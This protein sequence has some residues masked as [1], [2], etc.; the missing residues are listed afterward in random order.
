L[1]FLDVFDLSPELEEEVR[2]LKEQQKKEHNREYKKEQKKERSIPN[3][4][5]SLVDY[6][7]QEGLD[8]SKSARKKLAQEYGLDD[9][10]YS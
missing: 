5:I 4:N 7:A 8:S 9:Y 3:P 6:L 1:S 2:K 10:D